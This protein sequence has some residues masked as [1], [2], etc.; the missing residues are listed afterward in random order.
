MVNGT[1][2]QADA[3]AAQAQSD[4]LTAYNVLAGEPCN[5][6]L[7]GQNLGGLTLTPGVYCFAAG[8]Q[9]TGTLTLNAQ[10]NAGAVFIF[11]IGTAFTTA[12]GA[13]VALINGASA[14]NVYFQVGSSATLGT[15]S[16]IAGN[17]LANASV[18]LVTGSALTGRAF[19]L[20]GAVTLDSNTVNASTCGAG[21]SPSGGIQVCK[22]AGAGVVAGTNFSFNV[23]G[24][25]VAIAAGAGPNGT[26][27]SVLTVPAGTAVVTETVPGG[28]TVASV[29]TSPAAALVSSSLSAGTATV[30]VTANSVTT[31]TYTDTA[32]VPPANGFVQVCK[33]AG[34]GVAVGTNFTFNVA[35][36][37]QTVTAGAAP[38]GT[39]GAPVAAPAGTATVAETIP[40]GVVVAGVSTSPG[41]ALLVS[42]NLATGMATVTVMSGVQTI[43]TYVDTALPIGPGSGFL[44]VC[45]V[46]G[47][48]VTVGTNFGFSVAGTPI[49]VMAGAAPGGTCGTAIAVPAGNVVVTETIPRARWWLELAR[50][51]APV[52]W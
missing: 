31:V 40:A 20:N 37:M 52:C 6:T 38:L 29:T 11:K 19:A 14:C 30:T 2:H 27:S 9:L 16:Q 32:G 21:G 45:K 47:A 50:C 12:T 26:C 13:S 48:G 46:A 5:T 24:T 34:A 44:Q 43:V 42:S 17:I 36:T 39:C 22:V 8:A 15:G 41:A 23:A 7:T 35:G 25:A 33:V 49:T 4:A 28:T 1:K 3:A 51:Q 10:G 18:T